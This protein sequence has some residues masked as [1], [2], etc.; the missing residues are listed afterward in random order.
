MINGRANNIFLVDISSKCFHSPFK[1]SAPEGRWKMVSKHET[2]LN[3]CSN[4]VFSLTLIFCAVYS[5]DFSDVCYWVFP[6]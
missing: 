3:L 2:G 6:Q 5:S 4:I 1:N